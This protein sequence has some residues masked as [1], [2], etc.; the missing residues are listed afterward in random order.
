MFIQL[1][2]KIPSLLQRDYCLRKRILEGEQ[3]GA[4]EERSILILVPYI[5]SRSYSVLW[6]LS[7]IFL[8]KP[9]QAKP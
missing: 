8:K 1:L 5:C 7:L 6:I 3:V 9:N 4:G 2:V